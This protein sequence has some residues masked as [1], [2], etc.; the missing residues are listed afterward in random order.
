MQCIL[1]WNVNRLHIPLMSKYQKMALVEK[2]K[3]ISSF[4]IAFPEINVQGKKDLK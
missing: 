1:H 4:Y 2:L 3:E